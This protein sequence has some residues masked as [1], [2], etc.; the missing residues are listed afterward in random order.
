MTKDE[1]VVEDIDAG[2]RTIRLNRPD[3]LNALTPDMVSGLTAAVTVHRACRVIVITGTGRGFCAGVDIAGAEE[4]Q[5]GRSNADAYAMQERFAG[6]IL[7]IA[8]SGAPVIAGINGP[9]AGA[10]LAIALAAD[11]RLALPPPNSSSAPPTSGS[12]PV[13][14]ASA[15]SCPASSAS[16]GP[17]TSC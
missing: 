17:R 7:A 9:A 1:L 4:R 10:G 14:A 15:S 6:M 16:A 3:R 12:R 5:R 2:V 11:I 13:N 8:R